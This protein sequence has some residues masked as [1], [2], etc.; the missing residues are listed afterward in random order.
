MKACDTVKTL[1]IS[2]SFDCADKKKAYKWNKR[3]YPM[4]YAN[5]LNVARRFVKAG[6]GQHLHPLIVGD[7]MYD[8]NRD[9]SEIV[10]D[11]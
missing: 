5:D 3:E 10:D 8:E 2:S 9:G 1:C 7:G 6:G 11:F 4:L